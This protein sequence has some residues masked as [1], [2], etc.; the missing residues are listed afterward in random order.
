MHQNDKII[1]KMFHRGK[2]YSKGYCR[3][4]QVFGKDPSLLIDIPF[5]G[6]FENKV[7]G[8]IQMIAAGGAPTFANGAAV[9]DGTQS[10]K[11]AT[12][13]DIGSDKITLIYWVKSTQ[14]S[15]G[16]VGEL[17][18]DFNGA[19]AF[20]SFINETAGDSVFIGQV[21]NSGNNYCAGGITVNNG[22]WHFVA[23]TIDREAVIENS[24]TIDGIK[25]YTQLQ[26]GNNTGN[27]DVYP[28]F[29]GQRGGFSNGL[30]GELKKYQL[31]NRVLSDAEILAK[32]ESAF[33]SVL[34]INAV[35][36]N[37]NLITNTNGR[38]GFFGCKFYEFTNSENF[39]K[40]RYKGTRVAKAPGEPYVA[41]LTEKPDG[42]YNVLLDDAIDVLQPIDVVLDIP[43]GSNKIY[44]NWS[45]Q[46]GDTNLELTFYK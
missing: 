12:P 22:V 45:V 20:A 6:D 18:I 36:S 27:F 38:V 26:S 28:F 11:T 35:A 34:K 8:G 43:Q 16:M 30:I 46:Q 44:F 5:N 42:S 4:N 39:T 10:I 25:Q 7:P 29:I 9:F 13:L 32:Y 31:Y 1:S 3:E 24:V 41:V 15:I 21:G 17:S 14:T 33:S 19:N 37:D 23:C 40:V 2:L